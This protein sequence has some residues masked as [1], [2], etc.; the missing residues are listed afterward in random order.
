MVVEVFPG[1]G[2]RGGP[3]GGGAAAGEPQPPAVPA[4]KAAPVD[5]KARA[6]YLENLKKKL[7]GK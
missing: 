4:P 1:G 3:R 6:A 5:D 2:P 7:G